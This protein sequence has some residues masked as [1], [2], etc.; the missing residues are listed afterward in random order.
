MLPGCF[1]FQNRVKDI[2]EYV[3]P[4]DFI[5]EMDIPSANCEY[6]L[7]VMNKSNA[8]AAYVEWGDGS[9]SSPKC[10]GD[11]VE[12]FPHTYAKAGTYTLKF[13]LNGTYSMQNGSMFFPD[14]YVENMS[15]REWHSTTAAV[16]TG[17]NTYNKNVK[18]ASNRH[19]SSRR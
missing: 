9:T 13:R 11:Y 10:S 1:N 16:Q 18:R 3:C 12:A 7:G 15:D 4:F 2:D 19:T 5:W 8:E 6:S 14:F 17:Q